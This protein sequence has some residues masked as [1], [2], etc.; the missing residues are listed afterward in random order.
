[1]P[2]PPVS[3][4][5]GQVQWRLADPE[6]EL[7]AVRLWSDFDLGD[8]TFTWSG[9]SW[10]LR[11]RR[12]ALPPVDRLE[13]LFEVTR[14]GGTGSQLDPDNPL[15]VGGAFGDHSVLTL[16][17]RAPSWLDLEPVEGTREELTVAGLP[18]GDLHAQVWS[19]AGAEPGDELPLLLS[20][21]GPEMD[22]LGELTR[23][24]GAMIALRQ[25][26]GTGGLPPIRVGLLVPGARDERYAA[27]PEYADALCDHLL[28]A[29]RTLAPGRSRPVLIGQSLGAVAALHAEWTHP[30]T[31]GGLL[32]QSGSFFTPELDGHESG[33]ASWEPVTRFVGQVHEA[34]RAPSQLP[35]GICFGTAEENAANNRLLA[36]KLAALGLP[37]RVGEVRDAHT[38]TCWRD[39]LDPHLVDLVDAAV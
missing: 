27:N 25:T 1:M 6:H 13:Y 39:L 36:A 10:E 16:D 22:S 23:F 34:S 33:F 37:V 32:L 14:D 38:F 4:Q 30:G 11:R 8:T 2:P 7:D 12:D 28:P 17:Y 29:L 24:V 26:Q 18:L 19:P 9:G 21:D 5:Q 35:V 31:F 20:H 3:A 15:R